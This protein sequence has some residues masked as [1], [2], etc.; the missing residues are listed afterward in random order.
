MMSEKNGGGDGG[1]DG[2]KQIPT[3]VEGAGGVTGSISGSSTSQTADEGDARISELEAKVAESESKMANME[4]MLYQ[5]RRSNRV[6]VNMSK[7]DASRTDTITD[8]DDEFDDKSC[9][10]LVGP[11]KN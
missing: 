3:G 10:L 6:S 2:S 5:L 1:Y 9:Y 11:G 8:H 7:D 4:K